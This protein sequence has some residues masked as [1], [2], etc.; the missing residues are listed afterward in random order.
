MSNHGIQPE[1]LMGRQIREYK[2]IKPIGA[3]KFSI[4]FK[5]E[6]TDEDN[7]LIALKCIKIFDMTDVKQREKCLKEVKL[8]QSLDHPNVIRYLDSF[9]EDND[10][11]IAVEWAEKGDLKYII[12]MAIQ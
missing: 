8:L 5:A 9:I 10:L 4:V 3:G 2:V 6:K 7:K 12:R 1:D 11:Y